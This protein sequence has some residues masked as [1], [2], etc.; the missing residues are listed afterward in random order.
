MHALHITAIPENVEG[1]LASIKYD[2]VRAIWDGEDFMTRNGKILKCPAWFKEGMPDCRLDGELWMGRNTFPQLQREMQRKGGDWAG[3]KFMVFETCDFRDKVEK[4]ISDVLSMDLPSHCVAVEHV[5]LE[6][7]DHLDSL[8]KD[9]CDKGGEGYVI[10]RPGSLYRPGRA[11]DVVK[12]K[13]ISTDEDR[14]QG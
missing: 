2:G 10:R 4:R 5:E 3:I 12:I 14:W 7:H 9:E 11:G 1:W 13:R 6:G 8:E